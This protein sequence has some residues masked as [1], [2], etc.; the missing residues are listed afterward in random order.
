[1]TRIKFKRGSQSKLLDNYFELSGLSWLEIAKKVGISQR[2]LL[3]WRR[4]KYTMSQKALEKLTK[5]SDASLKIPQYVMLPDYWS[6]EKA[7]KKGGRAVAEKYGGPGTPS[8]RKKGGRISQK[9]RR[10][11]PE[12]YLNCNLRKSINIPRKSPE[13]AEFIGIFLGDGGISNASQITISFNKK[14]GRDYSKKVIK[15]IKSLFGIS[16]VIYALSSPASKNVIRLVVSSTNLVEFLEKNNIKRGNKVKNQ[17]DVPRWIKN[18]PKYSKDCLRGLV[19]TDG[20]VYYHRHSNSGW[21]SFN[22]G[23]CFTNKSKPLLDFV[24]QTLSRMQFHPKKSWSGDNVFLYREA[25]VLRYDKEVGFA[26]SY[27]SKRLKEYLK[28]KKRKGARVV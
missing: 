25:E 23:L 5:F 12:L 11:F 2:T 1:M 9:K 3:D 21:H 14:N 27:Q 28:I 22:I 20:G 16:P 8:G 4:E 7:A 26:N 10:L 17:V 6:I 18:D 19:D 13:L 24:E 15:L